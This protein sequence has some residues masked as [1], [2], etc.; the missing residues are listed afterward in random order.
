MIWNHSPTLGPDWMGGAEIVGGLLTTARMAM[1]SVVSKVPSV[2][3]MR[4][5]TVDVPPVIEGG[6][7]R[8]MSPGPKGAVPSRMS[9]SSVSLPLGRETI[10]I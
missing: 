3:T 10:R 9:A 7:H 4:K 2:R 5:A 8:M 6:V 1:G